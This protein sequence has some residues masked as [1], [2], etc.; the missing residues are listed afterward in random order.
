MEMRTELMYPYSA[1]DALDITQTKPIHDQS[2]PFRL[3]FFGFEFNY[4]YIQKDGLGFNKGL[5]S[6]KYPLKFPIQPTDTLVEE[7]PSLIAVWFAQQD[8]PLDKEAPGKIWPQIKVKF[9]L[10]FDLGAGVY[11]KLVILQDEKNITLRDRIILD[12]QEGMIGAADFMPKFALIVTWRNLT[13]VNRRE[14]RPLKV[15]VG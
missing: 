1:V 12:F 7:D 11:F 9:K 14:E 8:I 13:F 4:I 3:P 6:Y 15:H 2:L 10:F 5:P